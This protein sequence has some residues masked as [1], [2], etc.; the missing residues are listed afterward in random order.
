MGGL[1]I[2]AGRG[3]LPRLLAEDC[4]RRA[5]PYRVVVFDGVTLDWIASHPVFRASFEKPGRLFAALR[6]A[7]RAQSSA[8][9]RGRSPRPATMARPPTAQAGTVKDR[10]D[11]A[12]MKPTTSATRGLPG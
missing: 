5:E 7:R 8:S 4:A 9:S 12:V 6:S 10:E 1:A 2:V 11:S 3:D